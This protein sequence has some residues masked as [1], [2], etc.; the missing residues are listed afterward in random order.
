MSVR[1]RSGSWLFVSATL[2]AFGCG[3]AVHDDSPVSTVRHFLEVMDRS[4]DEESAL[5]DA[6]QLLDSGA[7]A[8]LA[9]RAER[10]STLS[11]RAFKPWQMLVRGRFGLRFAPTS[12]G[13][14]HER[15]TGD[16]AVV[17][18]IGDQPGEHAEVPLVREQG[19]WRVAL[20]LPP[21]RNEAGGT[22]QSDG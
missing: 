3:P 20:T 16:R 4:G 5:A 15:I 9:R 14:M 6:Y 22:R 18:V 11:G 1:S 12:P 17:T 8:A 2:L 19:K 10:A 13:G 21:M 7:Q